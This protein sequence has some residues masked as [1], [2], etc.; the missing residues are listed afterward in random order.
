PPGTD[1]LGEPAP[2]TGLIVKFDPASGRWQDPLGRNWSAAVRFSLPDE[3]VFA[4]N[5]STLAQSGV[6][7][8]VGTTLFNMAV[9]PVNG[10]I[11]VSNTD[12]R[13]EVRFEGPGVFGGSTVQGHLA[14]SRVTGIETPNTTNPAGTNV[15]PRHLNKHLNYAI[16]ANEPGFDATAKLH[17]LA[18]PVGMAINSLGT[19]LYVAAFGSS[20]IGVFPTVALE[21]DVFDPTLASNAYLDVSGGGPAGLAL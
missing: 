20:R 9:N 13:N 8:H 4:I 5:A 6:Y 14:E 11:Y 16:L 17:S 2:E 1:A 10:S 3:D 7:T 18:T 21:T 19:T 12:A 15:K